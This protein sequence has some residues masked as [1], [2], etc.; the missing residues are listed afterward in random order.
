[1]KKQRLATFGR[2]RI[3]K[4]LIVGMFLCGLLAIVPY[5][6]HPQDRSEVA[7]AQELAPGSTP[8]IGVVSSTNNPLQIA[9]LHWYNANQTTQF[10]VG[11]FPYGVAFDGAN[12]WV[13]NQTDGTLSKL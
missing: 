4:S 7:T 12:I 2:S 3:G 8:L 11:G 9:I 6:A 13:A 1:M 10:P 5:L